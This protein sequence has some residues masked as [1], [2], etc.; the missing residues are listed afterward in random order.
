MM[1]ICHV[2]QVLEGEVVIANT[3]FGYWGTKA[4]RY[5]PN[6]LLVK[7]TKSLWAIAPDF[8]VA[9]ECHW[10]RAAS[11]LRS[12]VVPRTLDLLS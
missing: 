3:E 11:L 8:I 7:L 5:Y 6:P 2:L 12:G 10:G 9:G 4:A 1:H